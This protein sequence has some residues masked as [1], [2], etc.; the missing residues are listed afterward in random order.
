MGALPSLPIPASSV[1]GWLFDLDV[2]A[3]PGSTAFLDALTARGCHLAVVSSSRDARAILAAT[4]LIDRFDVVMGPASSAAARPSGPAA[5]LTYLRCA[6]RI[7]LTPAECAVVADVEA[8]IQAGV[9]GAFGFVV[10]VD[11][12]IGRETLSVLGADVVVTGLDELLASL[13]ATD[14][15]RH[16]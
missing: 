7:G 8:G 4:G 2:V 14:L 9:L 6:A 16:A 12:G 1:R 10:G 11:K 3:D 13:D 5:P 15:E